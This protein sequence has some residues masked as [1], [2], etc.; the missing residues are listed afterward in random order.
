MTFDYRISTNYFNHSVSMTVID[1]EMESDK[2]GDCF[3]DT[4]T[5]YDGK[6]WRFTVPIVGLDLYHKSYD[7]C[8]VLQSAPSR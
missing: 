6:E 2:N 5:L 8:F 1:C 4:L 7:Q 3:Y